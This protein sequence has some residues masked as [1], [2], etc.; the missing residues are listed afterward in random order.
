MKNLPTNYYIDG[1]NVEDINCWDMT[2][3]CASGIYEKENY[4]FYCLLYAVYMNWPDNGQKGTDKILKLLGLQLIQYPIETE[5][6]LL[7]QIYR[8]IDCHCPILMILRY[9]TIFFNSLYKKET[10]MKHLLMVTG[11]DRE[12]GLLNIRDYLIA[13]NLVKAA[14]PGDAD[15]FV[16]LPVKNEYLLE[17]WRESREQGVEG[18]YSLQKEAN[19]QMHNYAEL[20]QFYLENVDASRNVYGSYSANYKEVRQKVYHGVAMM[21]RVIE[22]AFD[23]ERCLL[24]KNDRFRLKSQLENYIKN[25]SFYVNKIIKELMK[26]G[27]ISAEMIEELVENDRD[28]HRFI[29]DMYKRAEFIETAEMRI[30][31]SIAYKALVFCDSEVEGWPGAYAVNGKTDSDRD[32][33]C[34]GHEV[35]QHWLIVDLKMEKEA[36]RFVVMH[37]PYKKKLVTR[38]F[39]IEGSNDLKEWTVLASVHDNE[40]NSNVIEMKPVLYRYYKLNILKPNIIDENTARILSFEIY[41]I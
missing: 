21:L 5:E 17:M 9:N 8:S 11:Y 10:E 29:A 4:Y 12:T 13:R 27:T 34:S 2:L 33:W 35:P 16:D 7:N 1:F 39:N 6:Q 23:A 14:L 41:R 19:P 25:R 20:I 26:M 38:E 31:K 30:E 3:A 28:T 37:H 22:R 24:P 40:K 36:N 32:C 18:V 15:I